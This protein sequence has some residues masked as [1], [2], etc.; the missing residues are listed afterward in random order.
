MNKLEARIVRHLPAVRDSPAFTLDVQFEAPPGITAVV[1]PSG[2]GKTLL[3]NSLAGFARPDEGRIL[4]DDR[5]YF[6]SASNVH[7]P[8]ERRRCGYIFQEHALFPHMTVRE[9]LRF[10]ASN[11]RAS[12][13][14][15]HRRLSDVLE[16]FDLTDLAG[17]KPAELSGGQKQRAALAR[18]LVTEPRLLLLDEPSRGLDTRLRQAFWDLLRSLRSRVSIPMLLVTHDMEECCELADAVAVLENGRLLQS[19]C[20]ADVMDRPASVEVARLLGLHNI[21]PAEIRQLDPGG[22]RSRLRVFDQELECAYLPGHLIGDHGFVCLLRSELTTGQEGRWENG[23]RLALRIQDVQPSV[24]GMRISLEHDFW[25]TIPAGE[26][27]RYVEQDTLVL[28]VPRAAIT[29]TSR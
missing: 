21:A 17:R 9:N 4:V 23:N 10:A 18:L 13:L 29:F 2:S 5:L 26:Y 25:I 11:V 22:N 8:P 15:L 16:S 20:R 28:N 27:N 24:F 6:D 12:R 1:G 14:V 7:L 3:L 19:G